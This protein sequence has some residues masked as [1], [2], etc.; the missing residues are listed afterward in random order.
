MLQL[1]PII[2]PTSQDL[3]IAPELGVIAALDATLVTTA[4]Q[5]ATENPDL[6]PDVLARG[7]VPDPCARLA[8]LIVSRIHDL[9]GQLREYAYATVGLGVPEDDDLPPS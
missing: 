8:A 4:Y 6:S 5:L 1:N 3:A 9:R 7:Y 2:R